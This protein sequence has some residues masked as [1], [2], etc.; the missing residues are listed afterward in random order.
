MEMYCKDTYKH[1]SIRSLA[2]SADSSLLSVG[3]GN[4]LCV[5]TPDSLQLKCALSPA[6]GLDGSTN[7]ITINLPDQNDDDTTPTKKSPKK[8][9]RAQLLE[10]RRKSLQTIKEITNKLENMRVKSLNN[11]APLSNE[12]QELIY[13]KIMAHNE[14]NF[15]QKIEIFNMLALHSKAP[16]NIKEKFTKYVQENLS[17]WHRSSFH[18]MQLIYMIVN[19]YYRIQHWVQ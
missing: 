19:K 1:L 18:Q 14:L 11:R 12:E 2:F 6:A 17:N 7:K 15:Y 13:K 3:F 8:G 4:T 9:N 5:F 16:A 10:R